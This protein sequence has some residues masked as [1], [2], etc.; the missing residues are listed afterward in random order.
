[1]GPNRKSQ[2]C[3][4]KARRTSGYATSPEMVRAS[5]IFEGFGGALGQVADRL[6]HFYAGRMGARASFSAWQMMD[7]W[8]RLTCHLAPIAC[9][10]CLGYVAVQL[11]GNRYEP[12]VVL[13]HT[14]A[15]NIVNPGQVAAQQIK[16]YDER[17]CEGT[18]TRW[19]VDSGKIIYDMADIPVFQHNETGDNSQPFT[20]V[21]E[22]QVP[23]GI[24]PGPATIYTRASR[25]CNVFQEI[26]WPLTAEYHE[27][28]L[29][30][31]PGLGNATGP[32]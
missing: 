27:N 1:M 11:I 2:H 6:T 17:N 18:D 12:R 24:T 26:F 28:F 23:F 25:W 5:S 16:A 10:L 19:I 29:V 22:F 15:P 4:A 31:A 30:K 13:S 14:I 9:A 21:H 3:A 20:F 32:K 8:R 7:P